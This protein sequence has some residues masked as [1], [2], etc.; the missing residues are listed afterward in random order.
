M[1]FD[2]KIVNNDLSINPDGTVQTVYDNEKLKQDIIKII[3]TPVGSSAFHR[4]YGSNI[5]YRV[6][7]QS[8]GPEYI[9]IETK[10]TIQEALSNLMA[11][12]NAQLREQYVS[13][14]EQISTILNINLLRDETDPRQY[15]IVI[16]ILT[17]LLTTVEE[18]FSLQV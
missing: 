10:S 17:K 18:S 6:I 16:S 14:G 11:L 1:S 7:G 12:Q 5:G 13:P 3:L 8:L 2:L 4:W 9:E 15:Q